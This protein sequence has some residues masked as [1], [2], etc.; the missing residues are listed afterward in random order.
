VFD[1]F[2]PYLAAKVDEKKKE[3][4]VA[5]SKRKAVVDALNGTYLTYAGWQFPAAMML[6]Y[7]L[8]SDLPSLDPRWL[9]M[10]VRIKDLGLMRTVGRPGHPAAEAMLQTEYDAIYKSAKNPVDFADVITTMAELRHP[11][12]AKALVAAIDKMANN[13]NSSVYWHVLA[14][15][16]LPKDSIPQLESLVPKLNGREADRWLAAIQKL[17]DK[18]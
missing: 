13:L 11:N 8:Y 2:S 10:A 3:K 14:I 16:L 12:A 5:W 1:I 9:D 15:P 6:R 7:E 18:D 4:D 17:R